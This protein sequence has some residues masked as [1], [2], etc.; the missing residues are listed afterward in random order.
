MPIEGV[1]WYWIPTPKFADI[2]MDG[3]RYVFFVG[4]DMLLLEDGFFGR[5]FY[6]NIQRNACRCIYGK[7]GMALQVEDTFH[8]NADVVHFL[9]PFGMQAGRLREV[10]AQVGVLKSGLYAPIGIIP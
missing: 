5:G 3:C 2:C 8:G 7:S 10:G 4:K 9:Y 1:I 6:G